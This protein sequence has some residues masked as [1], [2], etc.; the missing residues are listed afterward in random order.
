M[1]AKAR[2]FLVCPHQ[3]RITRHI[4]GEDCGKA[5]GLAQIASPAG[6]AQTRDQQLVNFPIWEC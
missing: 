6:Q 4:G 2:A 1:D 5:P 3:P